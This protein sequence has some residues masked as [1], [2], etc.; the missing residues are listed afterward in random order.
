LQIR[1]CAG[2]DMDGWIEAET[3]KMKRRN[4]EGKKT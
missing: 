4:K 3:E 1:P 2:R